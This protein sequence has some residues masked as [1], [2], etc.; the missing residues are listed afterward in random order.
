MAAGLA[1]GL[2]IAL[3]KGKILEGTLALFKKIGFDCQALD[4][5]RKL[6]RLPGESGAFFAHPWL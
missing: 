4:E 2:T 5:G 3:P 1:R 6:I